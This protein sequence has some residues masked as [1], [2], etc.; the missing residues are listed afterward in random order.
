MELVLIIVVIVYYFSAAED[1]GVVAEDIAERR[2]LAR[3]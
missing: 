2:H 3:G 1:I